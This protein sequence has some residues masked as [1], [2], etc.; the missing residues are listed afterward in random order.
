MKLKRLAR[1]WG[2]EVVIGEGAASGW[3]SKLP[4]C[5]LVGAGACPYGGV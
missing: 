3:A 5:S 4:L 1:S 2:E